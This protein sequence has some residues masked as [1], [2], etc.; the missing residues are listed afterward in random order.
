M[1]ETAK[2]SYKP[3]PKCKIC[4]IYDRNLELWQKI[5]IKVLQDGLARAMV[6][7]WANNQIEVLNAQF[8][9][10]G[11]P[12]LK[13][14]SNENFHNHFTKHVS[15]NLNELWS[16]RSKGEN[17]S[18]SRGYGTIDPEQAQLA[19]AY[20]TNLSS[21][22]QDL[23][24]F[25]TMQ[26][27]VGALRT[28]IHAYTEYFQNY[29]QDNPGKLPDLRQLEIYQRLVAGCIQSESELTKVKN[30]GEVTGKAIE[31]ALWKIVSDLSTKIREISETVKVRLQDLLP[32]TSV[33]TEIENII[34]QQFTEHAK[35]VAPDII[36]RVKK[37]YKLQ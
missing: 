17:T 23:N 36:N 30:S 22:G 12:P 31:E 33:P 14:L 26:V 7:S 9:L 21:G 28:Q 18:S 25:A 37:D 3:E 29:A 13:K 32:G 16:I 2:N 4:K 24:S 15:E 6:C 10:D 5:H 8:I 35:T 34:R 20:I 19:S 27:M 11:E 1:D